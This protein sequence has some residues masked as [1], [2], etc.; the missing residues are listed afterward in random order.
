MKIAICSQGPSMD[1][2]VDPRFG[3][4]ACF[5]L[6]DSETGEWEGIQ[7]PNAQAGGGAGIQAAQ[8]LANRGV[9]AVLV[10]N[11]GPN[12]MA[13]LNAAGIKV[14]AGISGTV[15]DTLER[16]RQGKLILSSDPTVRP[17]FGLGRGAGA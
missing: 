12:A 14:Y 17:H 15:A 7:N 9:G 6:V 5:V 10:G 3:R 8:L 13:A 1:S 2:Q 11:I 16:Y 4:C